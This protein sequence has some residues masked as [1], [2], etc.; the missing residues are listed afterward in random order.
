MSKFATSPVMENAN[1]LNADYRYISHVINRQTVEAVL[2]EASAMTGVPASLASI[3]HSWHALCWSLQW[4]A[5]PL[6]ELDE[7]A[8]R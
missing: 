4:D 3:L 8:Q 5:T 7:G 6:D 2:R 1:R